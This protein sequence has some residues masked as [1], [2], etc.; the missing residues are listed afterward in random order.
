MIRKEKTLKSLI[1]IAGMICSFFFVLIRV[2][3]LRER[4]T[5]S[6]WESIGDLGRLYHC[7]PFDKPIPI[8]K[9]RESKGKIPDDV[10]LLVFGDSFSNIAR[11]S[12]IID[13][14]EKKF[15]YSIYNKRKIFVTDH[16]T[17]RQNTDAEL[18]LLFVM[19]ERGIFFMDTTFI[20]LNYEGPSNPSWYLLKI[21]DFIKGLSD[22]YKRALHQTAITHSI[23]KKIRTL[24]YEY[25]NHSYQKLAPFS[26][27][28]EPILFAYPSFYRKGGIYTQFSDR[29][30]D[31]TVKVF[32]GLKKE[33]KTTYNIRLILAVV[34]NKI[35]VYHRHLDIKY[36]NL[37]PRLQ[38]KLKER[39][40]DYVNL[41][42]DF[43]ALDTTLLYHRTDIH[44][45]NK[46][47]SIASD[48]VNSYLK[49]LQL[50]Q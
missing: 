46:G 36:H 17:A 7:K 26:L 39:S 9:R 29:D 47:T 41:Y 10:N 32:E 27:F 12:S 43:K 4:C 1:I 49:T 13:F 20:T 44:W 23:T 45:N 5:N 33:L 31:T 28:G 40:I 21:E 3:P 35:T 22:R 19:S 50:Q 25:L 37:L 15:N 30:L 38:E 2:P 11:D 16:L 42:D 18:P 8:G 48:K 14:L 24:K 34:P 6:N